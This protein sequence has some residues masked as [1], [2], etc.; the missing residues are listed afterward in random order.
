MK[1]NVHTKTFWYS[2][3]LFRDV[4]AYVPHNETAC[5]HQKKILNGSQ[6]DHRRHPKIIA[7]SYPTQLAVGCAVQSHN[8]CQNILEHE[9]EN[10]YKIRD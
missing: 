9:T 6:N 8:N 10:P 1:I 4:F 2:F 5:G 3:F 7:E